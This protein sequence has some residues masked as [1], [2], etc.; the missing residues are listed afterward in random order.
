M[1][2][3]HSETKVRGIRRTQL[4]IP[5][6]DFAETRSGLGGVW[7]GGPL[8]KTPTSEEGGTHR[9]GKPAGNLETSLFCSL[10]PPILPAL[11]KSDFLFPNSQEQLPLSSQPNCCTEQPV[12]CMSN[13]LN[14]PLFLFQLHPPSL[15]PRQLL[16]SCHGRIQGKCLHR[17]K[18][19]LSP[20]CDAR[21]HRNAGLAKYHV[22]HGNR[23]SPSNYHKIQIQMWGSSQ[24]QIQPDYLPYQYLDHT[25]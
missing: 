20:F 9:H 2:T 25:F 8:R 6:C 13:M 10:H 22:I 21:P 5:V 16:C 7:R 15:P 18:R 19:G 3:A 11:F 17:N 24:R 1:E 4:C 14:T 12:V 23:P